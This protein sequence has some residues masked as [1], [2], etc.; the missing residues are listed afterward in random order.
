M[1]PGRWD[2]S[3]W[4]ESSV[5]LLTPPLH[6]HWKAN[7][8]ARGRRERAHG[9]STSTLKATETLGL[10]MSGSSSPC[11]SDRRPF[12]SRKATGAA[13]A[14]AAAAAVVHHH[15]QPNTTTVTTTTIISLGVSLMTRPAG[16]RRAVGHAPSTA[17][18]HGE[19]RQGRSPAPPNTHTHTHPHSNHLQC[20]P[21][22]PVHTVTTVGG[23]PR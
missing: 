9:A 1:C 2:E 4:G 20:A 14:A 21:P 12:C 5:I 15:H 6:P 7:L 13:A 16:G 23:L 17:A 18:R 22:R 11:S 19:R 3:A 10:C 8:M